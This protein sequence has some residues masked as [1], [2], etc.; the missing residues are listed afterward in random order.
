MGINPRGKSD[1]VY[2]N[3]FKESLKA[4]E[5]SERKGDSPEKI[6]RLIERIINTD[7]P[8]LRYRIGPS[9]TL[10]GLKPFIP[11]RIVETIITRY[12]SSNLK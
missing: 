4:V 7:S 1:P 2:Q 8:R 11:E 5:E 3:R 10:I 6:A 12:Y 9:S